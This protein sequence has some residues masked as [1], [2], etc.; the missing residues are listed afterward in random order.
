MFDSF[1][2]TLYKPRRVTGRTCRE[3]G[4]SGRR[5]RKLVGKT[6]GNGDNLRDKGIDGKIILMLILN[7][8]DARI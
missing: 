5:D 1:I 7:K 2:I 3:L 4:G 8:L 6:G